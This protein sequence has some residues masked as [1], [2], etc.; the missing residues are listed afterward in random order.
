MLCAARAAVAKFNELRR[1]ELCVSLTQIKIMLMNG[2]ER[3]RARKRQS[4][5]VCRHREITA[6][7]DGNVLFV[8]CFSFCLMSAQLRRGIAAS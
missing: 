6:K 5:F 3:E 1:Q 4:E 2:R 7:D 8:L